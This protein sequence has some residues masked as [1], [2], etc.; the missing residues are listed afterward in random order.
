MSDDNRGAS[1]MRA[2]DAYATPPPQSRFQYWILAFPLCRLG[3]T[4]RDAHHHPMGDAVSSQELNFFERFGHRDDRHERRASWGQ[5]LRDPPGGVVTDDL[6]DGR[7]IDGLP[8]R[9]LQQK[10]AH[11]LPQGI[12]PCRT[13]FPSSLPRPTLQTTTQCWSQTPL[14]GSRTAS[15]SIGAP[16]SLRA[17]T[18][19]L[20]DMHAGW[21]AGMDNNND[22]GGLRSDKVRDMAEP[23]AAVAIVRARQP[24]ESILLIRRSEREDDPWSGHWSFPGGRRDPGDPDLLHTALRELEEE[25]SIRLG[26]EHREAALQPVLARRR[27][28][29]YVLVAP[30]VFD[31]EVELPTVLDPREAVEA[32][33]LPL[34][35][36]R[37]PTRHYLRAVP[38]LP[39]DWLFPAIDLNGMPL[40]GFT[41][42]LGTD[43]LGLLPGQSAREEAGH[44][45]ACR[46][47][48]FL[49]CHGL[50]LRSGWE[51]RIEQPAIGEPQIAKVAMV[52]GAIPAA[53]VVAHFAVPG[54]IFPGIN[55]L[56]VRPHHIRMVGLAFEEYL[57]LASG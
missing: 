22:L 15:R 21:T 7:L 39:G 14:R 2:M 36:W 45:M 35:L 49:L 52:E 9:H 26:R 20:C 8:Y 38:E 12:C 6:P 4:A 1:R 55:L 25:C 50:K 51:E 17:A 33:W 32:V 42:R 23:K 28:G 27:T 43:W 44:G 11:I 47:L 16:A 56:E 13:Y 53:L 30:F 24:R 3:L 57:I 31:V 54:E 5:S 41:Y 18:P 19:R 46:V 48:D 34:D 37:D 10:E 40:W 29:P